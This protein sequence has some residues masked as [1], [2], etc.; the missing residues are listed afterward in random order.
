MNMRNGIASSPLRNSEALD[1]EQECALPFGKHPLAKC[2]ACQD[3]NGKSQ[4]NLKG[5]YARVRKETMS[6]LML[7]AMFNFCLS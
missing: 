6:R 4:G 5:T 1:V 3:H 7:V 2:I